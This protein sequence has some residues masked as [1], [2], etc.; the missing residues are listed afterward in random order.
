MIESASLSALASSGLHDQSRGV[1]ERL[2][3]L[4]EDNERARRSST[5]ARAQLESIH[6]KFG[7]RLC[8]TSPETL[9]TRGR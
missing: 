4:L 6:L 5:E 8:G 7:R 3:R 2:L 9:H 1:L